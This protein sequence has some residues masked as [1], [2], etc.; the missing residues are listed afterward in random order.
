M[1]I[2]FLLDTN[3]LSEPLRPRPDPGFMR[4]LERRRDEISTAAPVWH[5]L[6]FGA[7]RLPAGARR[8]LVEKYLESVLRGNL[9]I[10]PYDARAAEWHAEERARLVRLGKTPPFVDGQIAAIAAINDLE[11]VT[12]NL[13]DFRG[14]HGVKATDWRS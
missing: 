12:T 11:I 4:R 2:R 14:F 1:T 13:E 5:E 8:S 10:Y 3:A 7:L 9:V 6:L